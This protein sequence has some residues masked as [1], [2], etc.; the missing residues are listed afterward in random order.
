[1]AESDNLNSSNTPPGEVSN[2]NSVVEA[3]RSSE[4][5]VDVSILFFCIVILQ[6]FFKPKLTSF[7]RTGKTI[8]IL[9]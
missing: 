6:Y 1:M 3:N 9:T 2:E 4:D 7:L 5:A 8:T